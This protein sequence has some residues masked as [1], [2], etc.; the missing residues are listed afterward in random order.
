[1]QALSS[2]DI[3]KVW[4]RGYRLH[5]VDRALALLG[6]ANPN[7]SWEQL[8]HLPVGQ[9]ND[10]LLSLRELT[11]G[12]RMTCYAECPQCGEGL[13]FEVEADRMRT[14]DPGIP[15]AASR[16]TFQ[17]QGYV[18]RFRLPDSM[19]MAAA[20][21]SPDLAA[22]RQAL[23]KRSVISIEREGQ[24]VEQLPAGLEAALMEHISRADPQADLQLDLSCPACSHTWAL[25]FDIE[26]FLWTEIN[27]QAKRLLREVHSLARA[28]GWKEAE[29]LSMSTKR[30]QSYL[31]MVMG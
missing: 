4:E 7:T 23:L 28:Y 13:E 8:A 20:A 14:P 17:S 16:L 25:S 1:V 12:P 26:F 3:L 29:I 24:P 19:D 18:V 5:P 6:A 15:T 2:S 10:Q 11:F 31:E 22:A 9:L 30:R 21:N 27:S